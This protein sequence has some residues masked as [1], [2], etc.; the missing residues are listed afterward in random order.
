ML[1]NFDGTKAILRRAQEFIV[2]P[3]CVLRDLLPEDT[4]ELKA[5]LSEV[6]ERRQKCER[7]LI[8]HEFRVMHSRSEFQTLTIDSESA[9]AV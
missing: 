8:V 4:F 6:R 9:F 2:H 5:S 3:V 1:S 7:I